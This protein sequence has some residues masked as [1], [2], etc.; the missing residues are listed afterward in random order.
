MFLKQNAA[1]ADLEGTAEESTGGVCLDVYVVCVG[2]GFPACVVVSLV[3]FEYAVEGAL[4]MLHWCLRESR[5]CTDM[6]NTCV[7]SICLCVV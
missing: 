6:L 7:H 1:W 2:W 5:I 3:V 4:R